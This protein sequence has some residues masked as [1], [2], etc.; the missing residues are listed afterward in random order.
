MLFLRLVEGKAEA[1]SIRRLGVRQSLIAGHLAVA[2]AWGRR[3][4]IVK[5]P[6]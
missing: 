4:I 6:P 3:W 2:N 5:T 1:W